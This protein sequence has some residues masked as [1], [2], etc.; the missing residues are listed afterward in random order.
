ML[1]NLTSSE[2]NDVC[3]KF[4][5]NPKVHPITGSRL[6]YNKG[7][8][9][10]LMQLCQANNF[11][12]SPSASTKTKP[13]SHKADTTSRN[14]PTKKP[15][16]PK[17][18]DTTSRTSPTK[19]P[20]SPKADTTSR[21]SP[22]KK[23]VSSKADTTKTT[24]T[25]K[26]PVSP[27]ADTS[28][29]TRTTKKPVSP[30]ADTTKKTSTTKKPVSPKAD[31][32][33]ITDIKEKVN[34][35]TAIRDIDIEILMSLDSLDDLVNFY[36]TSKEAR[37]LLNNK[38]VFDRIKE[39][40]HI[41]TFNNFHE[42]ALLSQE[43]RKA[44]NV[45]TKTIYGSDVPAFKVGDRVIIVGDNYVQD[46]NAVVTNVRGPRKITI[47]LCDMFG[48]SL[49]TKYEVEL[50]KV[51][52]QYGRY[53]YWV[54]QTFG[55][56]VRPGI[57]TDNGYQIT[58]LDSIYLKYKT[59]RPAGGGPEIGLLVEVDPDRDY[60][61]YYSKLYLITDMTDTNNLT[62]QDVG[63][64]RV[65]GDRSPKIIN[66]VKGKDNRWY[67]A[68]TNQKVGIIHFGSGATREHDR[69]PY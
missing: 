37:K 42:I 55:R 63:Q 20:V 61:R 4:M 69:I 33:D 3:Q 49:N 38:V 35:L 57:V 58:S 24:S 54:W 16:S 46:K 26:K 65:Y 29:R 18:D 15:V 48:N 34:T 53:S 13:V 23:P 41:Y 30:K 60:E 12:T 10:E 51:E 17:A 66:V 44:Q 5:N 64:N 67:D 31:T 14:S 45:G 1:K 52:S 47:E 19:K 43:L 62:L 6:I 9:N 50:K 7:P 59:R 21:T 39:K 22:T 36:N 68:E 56:A 25:T 27:K 40:F 28:K 8:Y 11:P 2:I 32:T